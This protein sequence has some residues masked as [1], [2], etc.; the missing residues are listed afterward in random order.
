M[1]QV[2]DTIRRVT[3][4]MTVHI[5]LVLGGLALLSVGGYTTFIRVTLSKQETAAAVDIA[6]RQR[7]LSQR[8]AFLAWRAL[9]AEAPLARSEVRVE[10]NDA[11]DLMERSHGA[12]LA[13]ARGPAGRPSR[14]IASLFHGPAGTLDR[15][16]RDFLVLARRVAAVPD[17]DLALKQDHPDLIALSGRAGDMARAL[18]ALVRQYQVE[19]ESQGTQMIQLAS[20]GL[21]ATLLVLVLSGGL[22]FAP[23]IRQVRGEMEELHLAKERHML[24]VQGTNE[25]LWDW[26]IATDQVFLSPRL[27]TIFQI[28]ENER[29]L[30]GRDW[31]GIIHPEDRR[32][33]LDA[34]RDHLRGRTAFFSADYRVMRGEVR[35]VRQRGLALRGD[36]GRAYRMAGSV[37]DITLQRRGEESLRLAASVFA[38]SPHAIMISDA[39]NRILD[40][41]PA[42]T[43]VTG[44]TK[45]E[46]VGKTPG[47]LS[48]GRHDKA[49]YARMWSDLAE[50]GKWAGEIW[51]RRKAGE[52]YP[53][54]L[55]I[56]TQKGPRGEITH[57]IAQFSDISRAK[58]DEERLAEGARQ[59]AR[60]NVELEQTL[61]RAR[62]SNRA[63][64]EF[65]AAMSHEL[66]TPLNAVIG[67]SDAMLAE[68]FGQVGDARYVSYLKNIRDSGQHLL[69]VINDILDVSKVEAGRVDLIEEPVDIAACIDASLRLV[70][71]RAEREGVM[72][73]AQ[74][75]SGLP[76]LKADERRLKQ[77]FLN[78]LSNAI[79]F[80]NPGGRITVRAWVPKDEG[81]TVSV[82]DT[83]I[84]IARKDLARVLTPFTQVDSELSRKYEGTGLG[85]PLTKGL[86]E[87][88]GGTLTIDSELG[89]GT[90]VT[91]CFPERRLLNAV[92]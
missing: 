19:A 69:D 20:L 54:W 47:I 51:N 92:G 15:S 12:L 18:D 78:L 88:H 79:K 71:E 65:L 89:V 22:V 2:A 40:V 77:I 23:L 37:A 83:G 32:T 33:Y 63:K 90:T 24:A 75:E 34:M 55:E 41:N 91:V 21:V 72:L 45:D 56:S 59:L 1:L 39:G 26:D 6:G 67:F 64:S 60:Q 3:R 57:Y 48:S 13:G 30:N 10:L 28:D 50:E 87:A 36:D 38:H 29:F 16:L 4:R 80:T 84:G 68:I 85:L 42:F 49:F 58:R 8:V 5:L 17:A 43:A 9:H 53:E 70:R 27:R 31:L 25:G 44:Y 73:A 35:W 7:M 46:A 74:I 81:M 76:G 86:V 82:A 66:R 11:I 52:I 62:E 14:E 61:V